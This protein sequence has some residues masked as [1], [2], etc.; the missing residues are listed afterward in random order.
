MIRKR[1]DLSRVDHSWSP[2]LFHI[3]EEGLVICLRGR[4]SLVGKARSNG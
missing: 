1:G 2:V 4:G 3:K